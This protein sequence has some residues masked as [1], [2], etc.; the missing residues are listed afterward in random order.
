MRILIVIS[1]MD[2]AQGGPPRIA[3]SHAIALAR[4]G[5]EPVITSLSPP[6]KVDVTL[7]K[8]IEVCK[9]RGVDIP[10]QLFPHT[11]LQQLG[12]SR[13][14]NQFVRRE[15]AHCDVVHLHGVWEHC[16]AF[17]GKQAGKH[18]VPLVVTPHG[19]LDH[20][21]RSR[22][23]MKKAVSSSV[24]GTWKVLGLAQ[25]LHFG[26]EDEQREAGDLN[27]P[28]R[29]FVIPNG[30]FIE[31]LKGAPAAA[32]GLPRG[33]PMRILFFSRMHPKK[34]V[35]H[36]VEGFHAAVKAGRDVTLRI[37]AIAQDL[38]YERQV[39]AC[40]DEAGLQ[41]RVTLSV[42]ATGE[43][44]TDPFDGIDVFTLPSFEE[45]FSMAIIEAMGKGL[46]ILISDRCHMDFVQEKS[47]GVVTPPT[48]AGVYDGIAR[49]IDIG[50]QRRMAMGQAARL[51]VEQHCTWERVA[52]R[53]EAAYSDL[54]ATQVK[55]LCQGSD[56][57]R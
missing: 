20:W 15:I 16:L 40:V 18:R 47:L 56:S 2:P 28:G 49:L 57:S 23:A 6:A 4:R 33:G 46:P 1:S 44:A 42:S 53:L 39:Q 9:T 5:H 43:H 55:T 41:E 36:L 50:P 7:R 38:E 19:M 45:G 34:G 12:Y 8:W 13:A 48:A 22:S 24:F 17:A 51:W 11:G 31:D 26:T 30:V 27:L 52:E 54:S 10:I 37:C 14:F 3:L 29:P 25:G 32:E 35:L 21:S